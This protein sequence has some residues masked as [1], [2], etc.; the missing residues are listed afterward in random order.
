MPHVPPRTVAARGGSPRR[1]GGGARAGAVGPSR[2]APFGDDAPTPVRPATAVAW[3]RS[4]RPARRAARRARRRPIRRRRR[5][6]G[7]APRSATLTAARR[8]RAP[9]R[10][11]PPPAR[12][13][14]AYARLAAAAA[15]DDAQ[16][17]RRRGARRR[18]GG[19]PAGLG[20]F[21]PLRRRRHQLGSLSC[22]EGSDAPDARSFLC[23]RVL[24]SRLRP[25]SPRRGQGRRRAVARR[26]READHLQDRPLQHHPGP[27]LDRLRADPR[28]ARRWTATS[29]ASGPT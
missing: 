13:G 9:A 10:P 24:A 15:N 17:L 23:S 21:A 28:S 1:R 25:R 27:E 6:D 7:R 12:P 5:P 26:R 29:P 8:R 4:R 16:R 20:G 19:G 18:A 3:K 22:Q 14:R 11:A 2:S